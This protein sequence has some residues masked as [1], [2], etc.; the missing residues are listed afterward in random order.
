MIKNKKKICLIGLGN[1]GYYHLYSILKKVKSS[2]ILVVDKSKKNFLKIKKKFSSKYL[3]KRSINLTF[4]KEVNFSNNIFDLV[5]LATTSDVRLTII[6]KIIKKN[7]IKN[8]LVEKIAASSLAEYRDIQKIFYKKKIRNYINFPRRE[9]KV[10]RYIRNKI[11]SSSDEIIC[12]TN[13]GINWNLASNIFHLVDLMYFLNNKKKIYLKINKLENKLFSSPRR[14]FHELKGKIIFQDQNKG[15]LICEDLAFKKNT[16]LFSS[17]PIII[18]TKKYIFQV[19]ENM[20]R[21][22]ILEKTSGNIKSKIF[23]TPLQSV[24]T[25]KF[26]KKIFNRTIGLPD[27]KESYSNHKLLFNTFADHKKK[28]IKGNLKFKIT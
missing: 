8:I 21:L 15:V 18:E 24:L 27:F 3:K 10:Y 19:Y 5:I 16:K 12:I 23:K 1:I 28:N 14:S 2:K 4:L 7:M 20:H 6:K 9:Y 22:I 17:Q 11:N 13:I 25:Y 26:M